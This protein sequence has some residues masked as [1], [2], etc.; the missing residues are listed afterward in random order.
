MS[1][2][3]G[4]AGHRPNATY[5]GGNVTGNGRLPTVLGG[6]GPGGAGGHGLTIFNPFMS[7]G[8]GGG[9]SSFTGTIS[10]GPGGNGGLGSGGGG[11]GAGS[12]GGLG[13]R[14]GDGFVIITT[15]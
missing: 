13:G 5:N 6:T 2:G 9:A 12:T 7:C 15:W 1:G 8:G 14:G 10:G 4:G 3:A 11:G